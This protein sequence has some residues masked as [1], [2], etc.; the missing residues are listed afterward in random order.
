MYSLKPDS[1]R[2]YVLGLALLM[3]LMAFGNAQAQQRSEEPLT[4]SSVIKLVR[5]GFKDKTVISIIASRAARFDLGPDRLIDLKK[6][7]VSEHVILAMI[8]RD[9]GAAI[10]DSFAADESFF[11]DMGGPPFS[12]KDRKQDRKTDGS[13]GG[14]HKPDSGSTDIFGS[15]GGSRG[16]VQSNRGGAASQG[17]IETTG[18]ATVRIVRP[19]T[20]GDG[21]PAR[22]EKTPTLTND[23]IVALVDAGF[24]EGTIVRRIEQS[25][26]DYDLSPA[27]LA[28]LRKHRVTEQVIAAMRAAMGD[29]APKT[30]APSTP[31]K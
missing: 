18:S 12:Q 6:R 22:L 31:E 16:Q 1:K 13:G 10:S 14:D 24:S 17:D 30:P 2:N 28:D 4:N 15:S 8:A 5:A 26:A 29:E 21:A 7:G 20:E 3:G 23:S 11:D 19:A 27:K 9:R 25:P